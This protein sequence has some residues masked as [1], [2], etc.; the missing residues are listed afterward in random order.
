MGQDF[1]FP[2]N[3]RETIRVGR[4]EERE[5]VLGETFDSGRG[6][7]AAKKWRKNNASSR[8]IDFTRQYQQAQEHIRSEE[9]SMSSVVVAPGINLQA[10][11]DGGAST[12]SHKRQQSVPQNSSQASVRGVHAD[13]LLG[14]A[15]NGSHANNAGSLKIP[16]KRKS[17]RKPNPFG[18]RENVGDK[19]EMPATKGPDIAS[20]TSEASSSTT[21]G[22]T[23][24]SEVAAKFGNQSSLPLKTSTTPSGCRHDAKTNKHSLEIGHTENTHPAQNSQLGQTGATTTHG[25]LE[26]KKPPTIKGQQVI[27]NVPAP[28][29][30]ES[31]S[32]TLRDSSEVG[33]G[34]RSHALKDKDW[35]SLSKVPDNTPKRQPSKWVKPKD[36]SH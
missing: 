23:Q 3:G 9:G 6:K 12:S 8:S 15:G 28:M 17:N 36:E 26:P 11:R 31:P 18:P 27:S 21:R 5:A 1:K 16:K 25:V 14:I 22:V 29:K 32:K 7:A 33:A 4:N 34:E 20:G 19:M 35:P 13:T 30:P 2:G 24:S 10:E